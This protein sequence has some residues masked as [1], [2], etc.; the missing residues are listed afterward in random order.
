[1]KYAV[2]I[3][4]SLALLISTLP[5]FAEKGDEVE[6][7]THR[8][9][10]AADDLNRLTNAGD[11]GIPES[12]LAD[13]K[14]VAIIPSLVKGGFVFGAEH[15]RGVAS[16]RVGGRWSAPAFFTLTGGNW[17]AQIGLEGVD[18]VMLF[19]NDEG[20]RH[21][22]S[23]NWKIGGDV[24]IAAGPW[25]RDASANTDWKASSGILTYSR[26]KGAF[27]G[28]SLDGAN[29]HTD[30]HAIRAFYG[31]D[32]GFRSLLNGEV[33]PPPAAHTFLTDLRRDF[34]EAEAGK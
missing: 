2:K 15:G 25:G 31:R 32:Y 18:L 6:K 23:A 24:G 7:A 28:A 20:A 34:H 27:I 17:G 30:E 29:I 12:I 8:M 33:Q 26:A 14:C 21:L 10:D 22:L 19:M 11:R 4:L 5:A 16:C 3:L 9:N 1:M 13:A